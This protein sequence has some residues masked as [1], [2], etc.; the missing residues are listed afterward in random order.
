[1]EADVV[2]VARRG[3]HVDGHAGLA[4]GVVRQR[5]RPVVVGDDLN[6][7]VARGS[8][9]PGVDGGALDAHLHLH[10]VDAGEAGVVR[11]AQLVEAVLCAVPP[12]DVERA[13]GRVD[14]HL[15][16]LHRAA[17]VRHAQQNF[18]LARVDAGIPDGGNDL[19]VVARE[20]LQVGVGIV[21]GF[22]VRGG[23]SVAAGGLHVLPGV[24]W[25]FI[26]ITRFINWIFIGGKC[27]GITI[28]SCINHRT[29]KS[30]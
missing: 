14:Q 4:G 29:Y 27:C 15:D 12:H 21:L 11:A 23:L 5:R 10:A 19:V 9:Q 8:A 25:I 28:K 17:G 18:G 6:P 30:H 13:A 3:V 16:S 24:R 2:D 22:G 20:V 7:A 1:M 26:P